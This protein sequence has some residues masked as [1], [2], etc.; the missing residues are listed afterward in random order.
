LRLLDTVDGHPPAVAHGADI[1][2]QGNGIVVEQRLYQ[3][4][5]QTGQIAIANLRS[6]FS[7]PGPK[8][9]T[10]LSAD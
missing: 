9:S 3:L 10:S 5:R 8:R 7:I 6:S 4:I 1:D 2:D